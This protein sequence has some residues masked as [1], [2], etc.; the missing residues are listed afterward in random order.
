M[1]MRQE[2][3]LITPELAE[4][5]YANLAVNR[6][7]QHAWVD[8]LCAEMKQGTFRTTHQGIAVNM[9][10]QVIDG[11]HRLAAIVQSGCSV[12]MSIAWDCESERAMDWPCDIGRTRSASDT[13]EYTP[14]ES[15]IIEGALALHRGT[16]RKYSTT[17]RLTT[18]R[19]FKTSMDAL[20]EQCKAVRKSRSATVVKLPVLIRSMLDG[21]QI[22]LQYRAFVLLEYDAMWPSV[23]ALTRQ[24][25]DIAV[26]QKEPPLRMM[27][28]VWQAFTPARKDVTRIQVSD[29]DGQILEIRHALF[30]MGYPKALE[31]AGC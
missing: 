25:T 18:Y 10:G 11:Q 27:A 6:P 16:R 28:R 24:L 23:K 20:D 15:A 14:R 22:G 12:M 31:L 5:L 4:M 26:T 21:V 3:T 13:L 9:K 17:E 1:T 2:T 8:A 19:F 30:Q 29:P 7:I